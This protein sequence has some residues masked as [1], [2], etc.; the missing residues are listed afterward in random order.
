MCEASS[1]ARHLGGRRAEAETHKLQETNVPNRG[2]QGG[3]DSDSK[4]S[5]EVE[6]GMGGEMMVPSAAFGGLCGPSVPADSSSVALID[7]A[8]GKPSQ[9]WPPLLKTVLN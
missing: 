2:I 7:G 3:N 1:G 5:R 8:L 4:T 6:Q 9:L